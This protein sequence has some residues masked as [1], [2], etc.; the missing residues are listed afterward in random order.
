MSYVFLSFSAAV[1]HEDPGG[2][3]SGGVNVGLQHRDQWAAENTA[4]DAQEQPC[5]FFT[6]LKDMKV[7]KVNR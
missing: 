3:R 1:T 2:P 6:L 7:E 5:M 4:K